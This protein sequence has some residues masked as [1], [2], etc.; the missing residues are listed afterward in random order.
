MGATSRI[1]NR[2]SLE[3]HAKL[4]WRR[5]IRREHPKKHGPDIFATV[6]TIK[7][8]AFSNLSYDVMDPD[9]IV[10]STRVEKEEED[11]NEQQMKH[12]INFNPFPSHFMH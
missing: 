10:A 1:S 9:Q 7:T 2:A 4:L 11:D 6:Q 12:S 3:D 5:Q 8:Q